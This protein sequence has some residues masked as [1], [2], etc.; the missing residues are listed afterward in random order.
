M[1]AMFSLGVT[2]DTYRLVQNQ[3]DSLS[4]D[5][6]ATTL[7]KGYNFT[8][9]PLL[10]EDMFKATFPL[11]AFNTTF[12]TTWG[13]ILNANIINAWHTVTEFTG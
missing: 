13:N 7:Y 5:G 6:Q 8:D 10:D 12:Q 1:F 2:D 11:N 3:T 4:I 9:G